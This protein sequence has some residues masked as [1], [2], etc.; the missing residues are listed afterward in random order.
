M[1]KKRERLSKNETKKL[2]KKSDKINNNFFAIK[3]RLNKI[4]FCR[5]S[6][7]VSKKVLK[8]ATKRNYLRRQLYEIIRHIPCPT[9][10][11]DCIIIVKTPT[12][13]LDFQNKK[14]I[15]SKTLEKISLYSA[16]TNG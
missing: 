6:V 10:T 3:F 9:I 7:A 1:L 8:P 4:P 14:E 2:L 12:L 11:F 15:L 5:Y 16:K 13:M